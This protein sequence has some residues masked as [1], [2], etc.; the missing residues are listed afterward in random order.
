LASPS[1]APALHCSPRNPPRADPRRLRR[2]SRE[3]WSHCTWSASTRSVPSNP[4]SGEMPMASWIPMSASTHDLGCWQLSSGAMRLSA[5]SNLCLCPCEGRPL[6]VPSPAATQIHPHRDVWW[7][8][9]DHRPAQLAVAMDLRTCAFCLHCA[10]LPSRFSLSLLA[11][12]LLCFGADGNA[13]NAPPPQLYLN[14]LSSTG[15]A[16]E[17]E[18]HRRQK[19]TP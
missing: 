18:L 13:I 17:W 1:G 10:S 11:F 7:P 8:T 6:E 2:G 19:Q 16:S 9:C 15:F 12:S 4:N 14:A 5:R 3:S